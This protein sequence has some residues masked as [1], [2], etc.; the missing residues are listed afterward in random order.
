MLTCTA[1]HSRIHISTCYLFIVQP[2][3][4]LVQSRAPWIMFYQCSTGKRSGFAC[5]FHKTTI[6]QILEMSVRQLLC[7]GHHA[8]QR[9]VG[10]AE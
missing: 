8:Q 2:I 1:K 5:E 7:Y 3:L 4:N 9:S 10:Q 6:F